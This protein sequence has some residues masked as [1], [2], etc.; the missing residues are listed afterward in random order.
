MKYYLLYEKHS[1]F[2]PFYNWFCINCTW[3]NFQINAVPFCELFSNCWNDF[4]WSCFSFNSFE[5]VKEKRFRYFFGQLN[6][7]Q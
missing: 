4:Q 7:I 5:I 3:S 6:R 1:N 2:S